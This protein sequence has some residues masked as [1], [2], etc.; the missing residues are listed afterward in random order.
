MTRLFAGLRYQH[1][2][3]FVEGWLEHDGARVVRQ[4]EGDPPGTAEARGLLVPAPVNGH[5]HVG[6]R[7]ARG[8]VPAGLPLAD[9]VAPPD[10][11]KHRV[12]RDTPRARLVTGMQR[13]LDE[14]VAAGSRTCFDFREQGP[15]GVRM[16][17]EA[18]RDTR[19]HT[20][21]LGRPSSDDDEG[22]RRVLEVADGLGIS[23]LGDSS[24]DTPER[25]AQAAHWANKCLAI[26]FSE[27]RRE[28]VGRVLSLKPD[29]LVHVTQADKD[30]LTA[31]AAAGTPIVLC[32]RSNARFGT[33]PDLP[34]MHALDIP[35]ALGSD[36]AMFHDLGVW[37]EAALLARA[38]PDH[39]AAILAA[40]LEGGLRLGVD[41]QDWLVVDATPQSLLQEPPRIVARS[42]DAL[43]A[44]SR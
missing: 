27:A 31:I 22:L 13:A 4:G 2:E 32:P 26:H 35:L 21:A 24:G 41:R 12:L 9:V 14:M 23:G 1:G 44:P 20:I 8:Q 33:A 10:G 36:N 29:F 25:A 16:L 3:G 42:W 37:A 19:A 5:T 6:D 15:D 43:P 17:R 40:L 30:D 7:V 11:F 39:H 34:S 28:D 18:T 38:H